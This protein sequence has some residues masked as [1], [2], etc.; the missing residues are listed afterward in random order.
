MI[1]MIIG[2]SFDVIG[3]RDECKH[4]DAIPVSPQIAECA[5]TPPSGRVE[6]LII[7]GDSLSQATRDRGGQNKAKYL[8]VGTAAGSIAAVRQLDD[9]LVQ[10]DKLGAFSWFYLRSKTTP[11]D[12][13]IPN[14]DFYCS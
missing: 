2:M 8:T 12:L 6:R 13:N 3:V 9:L 4:G 14:L 1:G 11:L 10:V 7:A 5:V